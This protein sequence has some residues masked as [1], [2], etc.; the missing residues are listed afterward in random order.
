MIEYSFPAPPRAV[1][2]KL[3]VINRRHRIVS[4]NAVCDKFATRLG[5]QAFS[6][7]I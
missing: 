3:V 6:P 1:S 4:S 2:V 5:L 7:M